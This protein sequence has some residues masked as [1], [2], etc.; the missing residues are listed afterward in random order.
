VKEGTTFTVNMV[1]L[2]QTKNNRE[3]QELDIDDA[4]IEIIKQKTTENGKN[5][6]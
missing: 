5:L 3:W 2:Y 6:T 4:I 1:R